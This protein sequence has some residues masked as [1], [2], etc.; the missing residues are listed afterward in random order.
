MSII[1]II[2]Y[3]LELIEKLL[4]DDKKNGSVIYNYLICQSEINFL[5]RNKL[6]DY[7]AE[8]KLENLKPLESICK[9]CS[10][11]IDIW[12]I[13]F[14]D[15][16]DNLFDEYFHY[17]DEKKSIS[18]SL[19]FHAIYLREYGFQSYN[20][21][22]GK[23]G[24]VERFDCG[25]FPIPEIAS[26]CLSIFIL[27]V[28]SYPEINVNFSY[29]HYLNQY[30]KT[31]R[32]DFLL[33]KPFH[34]NDFEIKKLELEKFIFRCKYVHENIEES[35][36]IEFIEDVKDNLQKVEKAQI[37]SK[38]KII[39]NEGLDLLEN[40]FRNKDN[41]EQTK[42]QIKF[43]DFF[44]DVTPKQLK[45]IKEDFKDLEPKE[46]AIFI[47]LLYNDFKVLSIIHGSRKGK[48]Q[49]DFIKHITDNTNQSINQL[50]SK[51]TKKNYTYKGNEADKTTIKTQLETIL[52]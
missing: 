10:N 52:K 1:N 25:M 23:K 17:S 45:Q 24:F 9:K 49:K 6:R 20:T 19:N 21:L 22:I 40:N 16:P 13:D 48:S 43:E 50:F 28:D 42:K 11:I 41:P 15:L 31:K 27:I 44:F 37:H 3:Q 47:D 29:K 14:E 5:D 26:K 36:K 12:D 46:T 33:I 39:L 2:N 51:D 18:T 35:E 38:Y 7:I 32:F 34:E 4:N 8:T 30:Q